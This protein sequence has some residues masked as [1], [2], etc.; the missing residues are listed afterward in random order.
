MD[1]EQAALRDR[2]AAVAFWWHTIDLGDGIVT[3]GAKGGPEHMQKELASLGLPDLRGRSVLDIGAWDGFYS[4]A[5]ERLGAARVVSLDHY[6]WEQPELGEG[7]G[8]ELAHDALG[9]S[10]EKRHADF[11][12]CDLAALGR[13]DVVLFLGVLYHL[14]DPLRG[15]RRV[16]ELT[17]DVAV[18]ESEAMELRGRTRR[19]LAE[20][21]PFDEHVGDPTTWWVPNLAAIEA[22]CLAAGFSRVRA[23]KEPPRGV[24]RLRGTRRYRAVVHA[25]R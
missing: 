12:S 6:A 14:E 7:R 13:F 3:P 25:F 24:S 18:I 10:A 11:M 22:L 19:P 1:A 23:I 9:S 16:Y 20:F 17:D 21:F 15:M 4:F 8:Y 2:V 5:A